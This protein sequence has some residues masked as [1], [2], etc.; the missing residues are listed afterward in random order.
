MSDSTSP[1]LVPKYEK[2][3]WPTLRALEA[4]GGSASIDELNEKVAEEMQLDA[5]VLDIV[6][7]DGAQTV[8]SSRCGWSRSRLKK[9]GAINNADRGVWEMLETGRQIETESEVLERHK[10]VKKQLVAEHKKRVEEQLVEDEEADPE[11]KWKKPL[12]EKIRNISPSAFEQLCKRILRVNGFVSVEVTGKPGDGGIDGSGVLT[13]NLISFHVLFQ[14]KR[15]SGGVQVGQVRDFRGAMQGRADKG[16]FI[17]TGHFTAD[18][19]KEATRDGATPIDLIDGIQLCEVLKSS[20]LGVSVKTKEEIILD[21]TF[22]DSF[23]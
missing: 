3:L 18:A 17:T 1:D 14:C 5:E 21:L 23:S 16:L 4:L 20:R 9:M 15:Y 10:I 12:L 13:I 22:F 7:G 8:F 2:M 11:M 19:K 6:Q